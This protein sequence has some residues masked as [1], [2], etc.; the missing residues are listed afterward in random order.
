MRPVPDPAPDRGA[1]LLVSPVRRR[2]VD[3]LANQKAGQTPQD[4]AGLTA[5]QL[6]TVLD[7]HVTTVRFHLDQL[8]A[9]GIVDAEFSRDFGVGRPRKVYTVAS[10]AFD[11][12][13][14]HDALRQLAS[15]LASSLGEERL[16]PEEAGRRWSERHVERLDEPPADTPGRWLGKI[17]RMIDVL[18]RWGY[19]PE[20]STSD[21]GRA[22]SVNLVRCPFLDLAREHPAVVCGIHRGL[23][24]GAMESLG[25][26]DTEVSLEPFVEP[27]LCRAHIRTRTPFRVQPVSPAPQLPESPA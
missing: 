7:L 8:V 9:A 16:A 24:A 12:A 25:E 10:G 27:D 13:R 5:A 3:T 2:I 22:V 1:A 11:E 14:D 23:I 19:T 17:A 18:Q 20:L 26:N 15:L 6:A 4:T 21:N